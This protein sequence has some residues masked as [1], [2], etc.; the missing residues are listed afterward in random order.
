MPGHTKRRIFIVYIK[1]NKHKERN[2][3]KKL[4][5]IMAAI[6]ALGVLAGCAQQAAAPE[7]TGE[8]AAA[9]KSYQ[10]ITAEETKALIEEGGDYILIDI[11]PEE[12]YAVGHLPNAVATYAYP[13]DTDELRSKLDTALESID[14]GE[15]P[16]VIVGLGGKTGAE[17]AYD[18]YLE[19]GVDESRLC[20]LEGGQ[21]SWPYEELKWHDIQYLYINPDKLKEMLDKDQNVMIIDIRQPEY[22]NAGHLPGAIPTSSFPNTNKAQWDA[23]DELNEQIEATLDPIVI[24]C[25]SGT[26]GA[27]NAINHWVTQ[28]IDYRKFYVLEGGGTNW[29]YA[30]MLEVTPNYQYVTPEEMKAKIEAGEDMILLSVQTRSSYKTDGHLAGSIE[31]KAYPANT[32]DLRKR[33]AKETDALTEST[34]P[35]YVMCMEGKAGAENAISYYVNEQKMDQTRFYIIEGGIKGW[36]YP[37]MLEDRSEENAAETTTTETAAE[38]KAKTT[39]EE[40][41]GEDIAAVTPEFA[42]AA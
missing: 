25:M 10:Y 15:G 34:A 16:V 7:E 20:I 14:E 2:K 1:S 11:Q 23:L 5:L 21:M 18:Y 6:M 12:Q 32:A 30:D 38:T 28:G 26:N 37:E 36:P 40:D 35:I 4:S 33:L 3:M 8:E 29:P 24:V 19:K 22:Y 27:Y 42:P 13:A 31:T 17:N 41:E 39:D 9:E